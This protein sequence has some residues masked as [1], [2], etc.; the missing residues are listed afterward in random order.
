MENIS[1]FFKYKKPLG[2]GLLHQPRFHALLLYYL[3]EEGDLVTQILF[4]KESNSLYHYSKN[5]LTLFSNTS[6]ENEAFR[7]RVHNR[8]SQTFAT[9][10]FVTD[11]TFAFEAT[12]LFDTQSTV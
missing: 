9:F 8:K 2:S 10:S 11:I 3:S 12:N 5:S 1:D 7:N 4:L 6:H